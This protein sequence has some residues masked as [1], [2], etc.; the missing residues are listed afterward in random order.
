MSTSVNSRHGHQCSPTPVDEKQENANYQQR[1]ENIDLISPD[2]DRGKLA[3]RSVR[4]CSNIE[5]SRNCETK[6]SRAGHAREK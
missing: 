5:L 3:G 4:Y 1:K 2:H 6:M